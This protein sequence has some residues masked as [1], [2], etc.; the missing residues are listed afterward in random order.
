MSTPTSEGL[1]ALRSQQRG[2]CGQIYEE[3]FGF[4][5]RFVILFCGGG[6]ELELDA[7]VQFA[8]DVGYAGGVFV[9]K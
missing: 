4:G 5:W 3:I 1:S 9:L 6:E 2:V 7:A 8:T